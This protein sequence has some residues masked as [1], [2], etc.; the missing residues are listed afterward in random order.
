[1][2]DRGAQAG[3]SP[4]N[5]IETPA[6]K[7]PKKS[8]FRPVRIFSVCLLS[9]FSA[10]LLH[11]QEFKEDFSHVQDHTALEAVEGW[12]FHYGQPNG[13]V[14]DLAAGYSGPGVRVFGKSSYRR[15]APEEVAASLNE[16]TM[17]FQIKVRV[18]AENDGYG[19]VQ[20]MLAAND[21]VH[22]FSV[23]FNG[24][25]ADGIGDN[26][27]QVSSGGDD[28]GRIQIE[29]YKEATWEKEVWYEISISDISGDGDAKVTVREA[30]EG[31]VLLE[32]VPIVA[33]G[34]GKRPIFDTVIIGNRAAPKKFDVDDIVLAPAKE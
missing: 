6:M 9:V 3:S 25:E 20:V 23:C 10:P 1:M 5:S 21:G 15:T 8:I 16:G 24:G 11:A 33:S 13:A 31:R 7:P 18:M 14:V 30:G 32:N 19:V 34:R 28:W 22:A 17:Q 4:K 27:L 12:K 2:D 29:N 26:F